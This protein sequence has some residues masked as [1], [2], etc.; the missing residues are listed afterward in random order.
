MTEYAF[1]DDSGYRGEDLFVGQG[2]SGPVVLLCVRFS[3][4][5]PS[6]S[7]LRDVRLK[8]GDKESIA[9]M[10]TACEKWLDRGVPVPVTHRGHRL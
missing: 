3:Q 9:R 7:C 5:V 1:R 8:R 6:P 4:Q 2:T 10:M